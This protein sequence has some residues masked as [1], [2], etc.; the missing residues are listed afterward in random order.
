MLV[1]VFSKGITGKVAEAAL[2]QGAAS[3]STRTR[4]RSTRTRRW[5]P[6]ASAS[7]RRPSRRA[8]CASP[9]WTASAS[10]SRACSPRRRR[11]GARRGEDRGQKLCREFPLY[12]EASSAGSGG[13]RAPVSRESDLSDTSRPLHDLHASARGRR[14]GLPPRRRARARPA[15]LRAARWPARH[16]PRDRAHLRRGRACCSPRPA[17]APARRSPTSCPPSS[18]ATASLVSTGT[19]NLQEQI[20]EKDLPL[21]RSALDRPF[22]ADGHEGPRQLPLPAPV[23]RGRGSPATR[24]PRERIALTLIDAWLPTHDAPATA[25]RSTNCPR[26]CRS[27]P[28][29]SAT[30]ENCL[31][32]ECPQ[33][34]ECFVTRMRQR[35]AESDVVIVNHHLLCADAAVRQHSFGEVIPEAPLLVVDEAHQ[36]EDVATQYFGVHGE[37][38]PPRGVRARRRA[39]ARQQARRRRRPKHVATCATAVSARRPARAR[40]VLVAASGSARAR[41]R[42]RAR[43]GGLFDERLRLTDSLLDVVGE[44]GLLL[45][46]ALGTRRPRSS[47]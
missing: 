2:G 43:A 9:R 34:G 37:Q 12:P 22:T 36:L 38:L 24:P 35:A 39:R 3:R 31:G 32:S 15:V 13:G 21:L 46:D 41:R 27:G 14:P 25:P 17:P 6:A 29:S 16:G 7:A 42:A 20:L 33:F 47:A 40:A 4:S 44:S 45:T 30:T 11:R 8:A 23:R 18:A 5:S 10:S 28:T 19:K 1:D 26:T